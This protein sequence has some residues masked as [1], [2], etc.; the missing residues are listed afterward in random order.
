MHLLA[1]L[2]QL[3]RI[4][5]FSGSGTTS[6]FHKFY[7]SMSLYAILLPFLHLSMAHAML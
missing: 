1:P 6:F 3:Q 5:D 2:L 7:M 4:N